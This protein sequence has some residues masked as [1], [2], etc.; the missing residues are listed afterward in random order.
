MLSYLVKNIHNLSSSS[1]NVLN[2]NYLTK[3][4][5]GTKYAVVEHTNCNLYI[6]DAK[7][8]ILDN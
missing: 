2:N 3:Y 5:N 6:C 8:S 1:S 7:I 4:L